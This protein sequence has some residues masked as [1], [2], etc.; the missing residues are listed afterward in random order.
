MR[1]P[2]APD[3]PEGGTPA[4]RLDLVFREGPTVPKSAI[5]KE[6]EKEKRAREKKRAKTT[7]Q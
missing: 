1:L 6:Q 3:L 5:L 4:E 2:S 7:T